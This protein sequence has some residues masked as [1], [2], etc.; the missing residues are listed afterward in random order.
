VG[1]QRKE[2]RINNRRG[3]LNE[4][5]T[6]DGLLNALESNAWRMKIAMTRYAGG[7]GLRTASRSRQPSDRPSLRGARLVHVS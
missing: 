7:L 6:R 4:G 5:S 2:G 1:L 3:Y